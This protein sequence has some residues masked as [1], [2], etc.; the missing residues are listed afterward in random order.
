MVN[1]KNSGKYSWE[2]TVL[3]A[4][5][6]KLV[7]PV[8]T[9]SCVPCAELSKRTMRVTG[10]CAMLQWNE[11]EGRITN[12]GPKGEKTSG[13]CIVLSRCFVTLFGRD[14]WRVMGTWGVHARQL[15]ERENQ[16]RQLQENTSASLQA[17]PYSRKR[18]QPKNSNAWKVLSA[19]NLRR[20]HD[21]KPAGNMYDVVT[22]V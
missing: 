21:I 8:R 15:Q 4:T 5:S 6:P 19:A 1:A 14:A 2:K 10:W 22:V 9:A 18:L 3:R 12:E 17:P 20:T 7:F 11:T 16:I 13:R